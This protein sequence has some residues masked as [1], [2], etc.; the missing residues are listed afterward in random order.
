M[1]K[2]NDLDFEALDNVKEIRLAKIVGPPPFDVRLLFIVPESGLP[3]K[4]LSLA[5][6]ISRMRGWFN[7]NAA[8]LVAWD[9]PNLYEISVGDYLSTQQ[10]YLEQYT[11]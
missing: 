11:Y 6:L 9:T 10:I 3:D 7:P 1:Q 2:N 5:R 8:R 4:G